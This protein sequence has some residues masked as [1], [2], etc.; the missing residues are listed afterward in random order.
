MDYQS[1]TVLSQT[2]ALILFIA[3]FLGIIAYVF[4]PGNK[5][6]F[7]EAAQLPLE[8]KDDEPEGKA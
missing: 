1:A 5:K 7:D 8:D 3:L 6:K 2:V 4:W